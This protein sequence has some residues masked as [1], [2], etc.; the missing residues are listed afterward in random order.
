[1]QKIKDEFL[2]KNGSNVLVLIIWIGVI[3]MFISLFLSTE[4]YLFGLVV[5]GI[6]CFFLKG[7]EIKTELS[8]IKKNPK[9]GVL[10]IE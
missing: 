1:M 9:I 3:L 2:T 6:G 5:G 4:F 10:L 8:F 7:N